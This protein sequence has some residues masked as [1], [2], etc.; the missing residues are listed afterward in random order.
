MAEDK[1]WDY[2]F[3][4][5]TLTELFWKKIRYRCSPGLDR[6]GIVSFVNDLERNIELINKKV[7][8]GSYSF[9][10]YCELLISKGRNKSPRCVSRPT[11]RD[12]LVLC[13]LHGY[14]QERYIKEVDNRL[15]HTKISE[16]VKKMPYYSHCI[17]IDM[18]RFYPSI[19][20]ELLIS[21]LSARISPCA[22]KLVEK[23]ITTP[24]VAKEYNSKLV[25]LKVPSVGVPEGLS[26]SNLLANIYLKDV[27]TY[28]HENPNTYYCRYVDDILILTNNQYIDWVKKEATAKIEGLK[29]TIHNFS[30]TDK[31][32]VVSCKE[33]FSYLGY[34]FCSERVSIKP[35]T[36]DRFEHSIERMFADF[37]K[38]ENSQQKGQIHNVDMFAW[39]LN[40][41]IAG[42]IYN[43]NKYGWMFYYSQITDISLLNH[44]DW[45]IEQFY[46]RYKIE[47]SII[48]KKSF[49]KTY[50]EIK[51]NL[52]HSSYFCNI[53][54]MTKEEM[55]NI[56]RDVFHYLVPVK[57]KNVEQVFFN[58]LN[59]NL[60][61]L[62]RDVQFFS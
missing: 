35:A 5:E 39:K 37:K 2:W 7:L 30:E 34:Y 15:V 62:E 28:F 14:L 61:E 6:V 51:Y 50:H 3:S 25:E 60:K 43:S 33:G 55:E 17:K 48:E 53:D 11:I 46:D 9:T 42:C 52:S 20:H 45:L 49:F 36:L 41:K 59:A 13:A 56:I 10:K 18:V 40:L 8:N 16:I 19:N 29:L 27:D 12:K 47:K 58:V 22:L 44:L 1:R 32:Y 21:Q 23:A 31:S 24:T 38:Q 4:T 57:K 26:I 54:R